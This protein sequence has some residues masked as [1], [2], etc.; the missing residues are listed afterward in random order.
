MVSEQQAIQGRLCLLFT[1]QHVTWQGAGGQTVWAAACYNNHCMCLI[2]L[3]VGVSAGGWLARL[4]L[5]S[6][7]YAGTVRCCT[8]HKSAACAMQLPASSQS[9]IQQLCLLA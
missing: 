5:G 1:M 2:V 4:A 7:P 8:C 3:Q 9:S 6:E